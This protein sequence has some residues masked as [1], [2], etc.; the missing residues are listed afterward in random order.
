M[1]HNTT[2]GIDCQRAAVRVS[3]RFDLSLVVK[4]PSLA[5]CQD[6]ND[7]GFGHVYRIDSVGKSAE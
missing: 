7:G 2:G 1:R 5:V 6:C 4:K 3:P